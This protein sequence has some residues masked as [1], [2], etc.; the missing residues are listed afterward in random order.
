MYYKEWARSLLCPLLNHLGSAVSHK[1]RQQSP[2][3]PQSEV[4]FSVLDSASLK[5]HG[6][7]ISIKREPTTTYLK[8]FPPS[9]A[10]SLTSLWCKDVQISSRTKPTGA[11]PF[12]SLVPIAT[13]SLA[14]IWP[15]V[16]LPIRLS[17]SSLGKIRDSLQFN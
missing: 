15:T 10:I 9:L 3:V 17:H 2:V 11:V 8:D 6:T 1:L 7:P 12:G 16:S 5:K 4:S 14:R 13:Q